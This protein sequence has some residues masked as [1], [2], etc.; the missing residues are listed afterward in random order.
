ME[1]FGII[2]ISLGA[3]GFIFG[4]SAFTR[5]NK[6]EKQLKATGVLDPDFKSG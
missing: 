4:I 5:L 2:G 3:M 6:L 1:A